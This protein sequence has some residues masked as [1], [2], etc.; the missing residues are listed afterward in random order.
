[1]ITSA[2]RPPRM[3]VP[4]MARLFLED[5]TTQ[6]RYSWRDWNG[7]A[8]IHSVIEQSPHGLR[9]RGWRRAIAVPVRRMRKHAAGSW[10][11]HCRPVLRR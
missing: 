1:M 9:S 7:R 5:G 4:I 8:A 10:T 11:R 3:T 6:G 2:G